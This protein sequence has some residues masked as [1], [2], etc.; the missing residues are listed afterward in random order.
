VGRVLVRTFVALRC[1]P[2]V[3]RR[4]RRESDRLAG[5]DRAC[6]APA[7]DE[8]HAT[9]HFLGDTDERDLAA[10]GRALGEA[11]RGIPPLRLRYGGLGAFPTPTRA[12]VVFAALREEGGEAH[13]P[14]LAR[15]VGERLG[16]IG[17]PPESRAFHAHVTLARLRGLPGPALAEAVA[18]A[19][20]LDLGRETVSEVRFILSDPGERGYRYIDLTVVPL[21][22]LPGGPGGA[23]SGAE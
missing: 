18:G 20:D 11:A 22:G 23:E 5:L 14:R 6:R 2:D 17:Y 16:R 19:V 12:R 10:V 8:Y 9:L 7:T 15:A 21:E 13:L 1:G 4:L 3:A